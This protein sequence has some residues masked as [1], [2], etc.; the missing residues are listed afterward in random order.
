MAS[1]AAP[2]P[3]ICP[4][5]MFTVN[6]SILALVTELSRSGTGRV[7]SRNVS[8]T[9]TTSGGIGKSKEDAKPN[10]TT[11]TCV[12]IRDD[13]MALETPRSTH[14]APETESITVDL[15]SA[16]AKLQKIVEGQ[17]DLNST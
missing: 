8:F 15:S 4:C 7:I 9:T 1:E 2:P 14:D 11:Q 3:R 16:T 5:I 17:L 6:G 12:M 13:G 10:A